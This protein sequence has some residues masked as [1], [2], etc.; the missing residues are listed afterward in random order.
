M[1]G[2][3]IDADNPIECNAAQHNDDFGLDEREFTFEKGLAVVEF[4]GRGFV[5]RRRATTRGGDVHIAE[6]Q[7]IASRGRV[8]LVRESR[9]E[10][11]GIEESARAIARELASG[12]VGTV[13]AGGQPHHEDARVRVAKSRDGFAPVFLV[14]VGFA[15][16]ARNFFAP[17]D[18]TRAFVAGDD[19]FVE[20]VEEIHVSCCVFRVYLCTCVPVYNISIASPKE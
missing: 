9:S 15:F 5:A 1:N 14:F 7:P 12:A 13:R 6:D 11:G 8:G 20:G 10:E 18:E 4:F 16:N 3:E 17:R 19:F 2:G